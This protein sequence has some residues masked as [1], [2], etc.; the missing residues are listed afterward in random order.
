MKFG[1][2]IDQ[3]IE[4]EID[5]AIVNA[6]ILMKCKCEN[7]I[8]KPTMETDGLQN[9]YIYLVKPYLEQRYATLNLQ[10]DSKIGIAEILKK[11]LPQR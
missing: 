11:D 10:R 3:E 2:P 4:I 5:Q 1:R 7:S 6:R 8:N 9:F